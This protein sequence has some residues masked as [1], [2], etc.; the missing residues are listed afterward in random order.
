M[1]LEGVKELSAPRDVVWRVLNDPEQM[2]W[3][4]PPPPS[5]IPFAPSG[6]NGEGDSIAPVFSAGTSS[7]WGTW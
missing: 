1:K 4:P 6:E 2:Q 7:A 3:M 5:P